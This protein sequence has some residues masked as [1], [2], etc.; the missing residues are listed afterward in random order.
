MRNIFS[1]NRPMGN[2]DKPN[3]GVGKFLGTFYSLSKESEKK[4]VNIT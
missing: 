3:G 1:D 2:F 4:N